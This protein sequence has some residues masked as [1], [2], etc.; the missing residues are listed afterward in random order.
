MEL[1]RGT[2]EDSGSDLANGP[3][4][5][6][7]CIRAQALSHYIFKKKFVFPVTSVTDWGNYK[8]IIWERAVSD[9]RELVFHLV[10]CWLT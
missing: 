7:P 9:F 10:A 2:K 8:E 6:K 4:F 3:Q 1:A 5:A